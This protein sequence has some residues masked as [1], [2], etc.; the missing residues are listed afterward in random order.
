VGAPAT[1]RSRFALLGPLGAR[2]ALALESAAL[3]LPPL[4]FSAD[5]EAE[6]LDANDTSALRLL[7]PGAHR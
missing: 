1:A 6:R 2:A 4:D 3:L 7:R 5:Q